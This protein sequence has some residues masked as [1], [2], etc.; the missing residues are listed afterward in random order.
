MCMPGTHCLFPD[1]LSASGWLSLFSDYDV[2]QSEA[3]R[4]TLVLADK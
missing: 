2:C 4:M 3:R 1:P